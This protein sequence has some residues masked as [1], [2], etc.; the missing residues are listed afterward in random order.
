MSKRCNGCGC[1]MRGDFCGICASAQDD[2]DDDFH[3]TRASDLVPVSK[4]AQANPPTWFVGAFFFVVGLLVGLALMATT[5]A[6]H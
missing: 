4:P 6:K 2:E 3:G 1:K 5:A